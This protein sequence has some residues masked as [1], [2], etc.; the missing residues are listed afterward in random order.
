MW[1]DKN[2]Y[3]FYG[4]NESETIEQLQKIYDFNMTYR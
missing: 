2:T 1:F 3:R 4:L